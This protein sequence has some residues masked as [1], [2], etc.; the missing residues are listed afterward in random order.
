[1]QNGSLQTDGERDLTAG[2]EEGAAWPIALL[3]GTVLA[4]TIVVVS[5]ILR[6]EQPAPFSGER[7]QPAAE[8]AGVSSMARTPPGDPA[9]AVDAG[10]WQ[11][12]H[13]PR[14]APA[15]S[16]MTPQAASPTRWQEPTKYVVGVLLFLAVLAL[17]Y[18]SRSVIPVIILA[19][20]LALVVHPVISFFEKRLKLSRGL[21]IAATYLLVVALLIL[22]PLVILPGIIEA[23]NALANVNFQAL[24][25]TAVQALADLADRV[26]QIPGLNPLLSPTLH[27]L[28]VSLQG[29]SS[30]QPVQ[31]IPYE[32]ALGGTIE[33]LG[34]MLGVATRVLGP[35][36]SAVVS[37]VFMLLISFYLSL[38]GDKL[39]SG[40]RK[41]LPPAYRAEITGL[42]DRI[43]GVWTGFLRGQFTLMVIVGALVWLGNTIL[44]NS[45]ALLLGIISGL[46][47]VIPN[48]GP[49]LALIPGVGLAL[50][51]GSSHLPVSNLVFALIVLAF[52]LLVQ[53]AENQL[54]VPHVLGSAVELPPLVVIL[55][56]MVGATVAGILGA[57]LAVPIVATG[58]EVFSYLY[59]KILEPP[60]EPTPP[61]AEPSLLDSV[62]NRLSKLTLPFGRRAKKPSPSEA[63]SVPGTQAASLGAEGQKKRDDTGPTGSETR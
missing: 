27:A 61:K 5:R 47:E 34:Q 14:L 53:V 57:L 40:Y 62:R 60:P 51:F 23:V 4:G 25:E 35:V 54:I 39:L 7:A 20:L 31:P 28:I 15:Q 24:A 26:S 13:S 3:M 2:Q 32:A 56:V 44:G 16:S 49:A 19:A 46:L 8:T 36:V 30:V 48:L 21:S 38:S 58:R 37:I 1:M 6:R 33:R 10:E 41:L 17:L 42:L 22:I 45:F 55:G 9:P 11:Q 52:Y 63:A 18:L 50:L 29:V 59:N 43:E 12:P